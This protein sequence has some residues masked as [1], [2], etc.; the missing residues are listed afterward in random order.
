MSASTGSFLPVRPPSSHLTTPPCAASAETAAEI[1][2]RV[3]HT[4]HIPPHRPTDIAH[5]MPHPIERRKT[6]H[7]R[8]RT[9]VEHVREIP[10]QEVAHQAEEILAAQVP[11]GREEEREVREDRA[12]GR[13]CVLVAPGVACCEVVIV[14]RPELVERMG[15]DG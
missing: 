11:V 12:E 6:D 15:E 13:L 3:Q 14:A 7:R 1:L 4:P 2:H 10:H 9:H 5:R 8:L